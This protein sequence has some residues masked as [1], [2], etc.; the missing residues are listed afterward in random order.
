MQKRVCSKVRL[1]FCKL[2]MSYIMVVDTGGLLHLRVTDTEDSQV[3]AMDE[4]EA[5][6]AGTAGPDEKQE[7][8]IQ[9]QPLH[10]SEDR[11]GLL[12]GAQGGGGDL[13]DR[14]R[15]GR[16][17]S[18]PCWGEG[19]TKAGYCRKCDMHLVRRL[20][21]YLSPGLMIGTHYK[22]YYVMFNCC[23]LLVIVLL[24]LRY[25]GAASAH[26]ALPRLQ[27]LCVDA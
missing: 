11:E 13:L 21:N 16:H 9:M 10:S 17:N 25:S 14:R 24:C 18:G 8:G 19:P 2:Q 6:A 3:R 7:E 20:S 5:P 22:Y 15:G 4:G 27:P 23:Q 26:G 12:T 1:V